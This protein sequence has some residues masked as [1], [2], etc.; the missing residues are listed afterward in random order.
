[1]TLQEALLDTLQQLP[2]E[3]Q[4]EVLDF[5]EFLKQKGKPEKDPSSLL[6]LAGIVEDAEGPH[7]RDRAEDAPGAA[8]VNSVGMEP[9]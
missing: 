7:A 6:E 5:A 4:Q 8:C 9:R 1:M 2:P 3:Q